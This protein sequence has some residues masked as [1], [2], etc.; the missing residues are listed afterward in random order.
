MSFIE[1]PR[2]PD[3]ISYGAT[4][5]PVWSTDVVRTGAGQEYRNQSWAQALCTFDVSHA[6]RHATDY[7]V[8]R[9]F[10]RAMRGRLH[11]FRFKDHSDFAVTN[12]VGTF[13]QL[14][15]TTFQMYRA[16]VTGAQT[17]SRK[18]VKPV[19][20]TVAVVGGVSPSVDYTTGIV[21]VAS[22]TP[23]AWSGEFDVPC[24]FDID[25]MKAEIIVKEG[26]AFVM[27]WSSITLVELRL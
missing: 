15:S 3:G 14:T 12:S 13:V 19:T 5:G 21:T 11:G 9:D 16:Y 4:G 6:A 7:A 23:T 17:D 25:E 10:Y 22:G 20:G 26:A 8:L 27:G 18:I 24:R 2:F 1:T